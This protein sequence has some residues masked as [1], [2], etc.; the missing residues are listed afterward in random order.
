MPNGHNHV[1]KS[2]RVKW[3]S[4]HH[5]VLVSSWPMGLE[6]GRNCRCCAP[7][8]MSCQKGSSAAGQ[9]STQPGQRRGERNTVT[10]CHMSHRQH[11]ELKA[12][13]SHEPQTA[14]GAAD[15]TRSPWQNNKTAQVATDSAMGELKTEYRTTD[16]TVSLRQSYRQHDVI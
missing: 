3:A 12:K 6:S 4:H 14:Q 9:C 5:C 8:H 13:L 11:E 1:C 2:C 7:G 15:N 16:N 10:H